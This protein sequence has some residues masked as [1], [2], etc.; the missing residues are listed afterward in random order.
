MKIKLSV[1]LPAFNE[2]EVLPLTLSQVN[3]VLSQFSFQTEIIVVDDGS[4]DGT[5]QILLAIKRDIP[6]LRVLHFPSNQGHMKSLLLGMKNATG[7]FVVTMDCDLQDPPDLLPKLLQEIEGS[8]YDIVQTVRSDRRLDSFFKRTT[9]TVFYKIIGYLADSRVI[10][11]AADFRIMTAAANLRLISVPDR[12]KIFR[13]LIPAL[14]FRIKILEFK[15]ESRTLG[16]TKYP[17]RKMV[18]LA[19]DSVTTFSTKPLRIMVNIGIAFS[20]LFTILTVVSGSLYLFGR[21]VPGWASIV[22]LIL[23]SNSFIVTTIAVV[24]EYVAKIYMQLLDRGDAK[25]IEI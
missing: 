3:A 10:E 13:F 21:T 12:N 16:E 15:R 22:C 17:L 14:G 19:L 4:T 5:L 25:W 18:S 11:N 9:S 7:E 8:D 23:L 20:V 1:I 24:G 2:Q 6:K